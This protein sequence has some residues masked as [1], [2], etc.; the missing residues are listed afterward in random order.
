M[1]HSVFMYYYVKVYLNLYHVTEA[2]FQ[3]AQILFMI[4]NA[5]ND[6]LFGYV[7]DNYDFSWVKS[8]RHSILYGAPL[9]ALSFVLPWFPWGDY[10]TSNWLSGFQLPLCLCFYDA[11]FTFVLLA[12]CALFAEMS[13]AQDDRV[14][15]VRYSQVASLVGSTSVFFTGHLSSNL[16]MYDVFQMCS[17]V[18]G[19]FAL[20]CLIYSGRNAHSRFDNIEHQSV[21]NGRQLKKKLSD[22]HAGAT[23]QSTDYT[24]WQQ[25]SQVM[26]S[27]DFLCF[28]TMNFC[29]VY[30][31]T[32]LTNF[33][34]VFSDVLI[35]ADVMTAKQR[36]GFYGSL[37]FTSHVRL[38][39][40]AAE[41]RPVNL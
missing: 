31:V 11:M 37:S 33:A 26:S 14:R 21:G 9:F 15:L 4:W 12:Q 25:V 7:Q 28:V 36:A 30:H 27:R 8:R 41:K 6:P 1:L 10:S 38:L 22:I 2:W 23:S 40:L 39:V 5:I 16:E 32:F 35:P 19:L 3:T 18:I 24:M 34:N 13:T 17:V 20:L 29:Q